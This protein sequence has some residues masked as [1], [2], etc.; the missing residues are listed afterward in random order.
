MFDGIPSETFLEVAVAVLQVHAWRLVIVVLMVLMHRTMCYLRRLCSLWF[1][2]AVMADTAHPW[3]IGRRSG[4]APCHVFIWYSSHENSML[5]LSI[6][7]YVKLN[8]PV[9]YL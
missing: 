4:D 9:N 3:C 8:E 1:L 6:I 2:A 5:I 7:I